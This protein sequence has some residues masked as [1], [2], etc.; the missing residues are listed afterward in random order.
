VAL[1]AVVGVI[2]LDNG[3][4]RGE[5]YLAE[6]EKLLVEA[7]DLQSKLPSVPSHGGVHRD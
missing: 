3:D 1:V 2:H 7:I 5:P 4:V 6:V